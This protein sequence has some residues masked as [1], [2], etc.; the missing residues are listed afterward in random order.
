LPSE[1]WDKYFP[2]TK[3]IQEKAKKFIRVLCAAKSP[4]FRARLKP[5]SESSEPVW[6]RL[7]T[8]YQSLVWRALIERWYCWERSWIWLISPGLK[9]DK[10]ILN[11]WVLDS[12][13]SNAGF[14]TQLIFGWVAFYIVNLYLEIT[15]SIHRK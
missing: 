9:S 13:K 15:I 4:K 7:D 3:K 6:D 5:Y 10:F 1:Y 2:S 14:A 11:F 8:S 12:K